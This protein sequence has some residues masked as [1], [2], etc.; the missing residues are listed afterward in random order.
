M[1]WFKNTTFRPLFILTAL[2]VALN[3]GRVLMTGRVL[4]LYLTWNMVLA[5]APL[6][7]SGFLF[8]YL[9][10]PKVYMIVVVFSALVWLALFPNAPY[11]LTDFIHLRNGVTIPIWYNILMFFSA[12]WVGLLATF[13]SLAE[14]EIL[15]RK[16]FSQHVTWVIISIVVLLT[17]FGIYIGRFLRWNS[18]DVFINPRELTND[19]WQVLTPGGQHQDAIS[20]VGI[21]FVFILVSYIAWRSTSNKV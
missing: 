8:W 18:W 13:Y 21:F 9:A 5:I 7:V 14:V 20:F 1:T 15:L 2:A 6:L 10:R 17:S 16:K 19:I 12:A 11:L 3:V 4:D